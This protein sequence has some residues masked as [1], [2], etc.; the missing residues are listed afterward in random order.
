ML[1]SC[2]GQKNEIDL[3]FRQYSAKV[4]VFFIAYRTDQQSLEQA[5]NHLL[6]PLCNCSR[7]HI[8]VDEFD[9]DQLGNKLI[10]TLNGHD[11]RY[12]MVPHEQNQRSASISAEMMTMTEWNLQIAGGRSGGG[13]GLDPCWLASSFAFL[14][15]RFAAC[16]CVVVC[17]RPNL[18]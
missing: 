8:W 6:P 1:E 11:A 13:G 9:K 16:G 3:Q 2:L 4:D 7:Q 14:R 10:C 18:R 5:A 15:F 12:P 17:G